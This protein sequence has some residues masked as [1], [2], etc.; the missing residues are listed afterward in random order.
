MQRKPLESTELRRYRHRRPTM[1]SLVR[2][3]QAGLGAAAARLCQP[4]AL[5]LPL[6][7]LAQFLA[8]LFGA[9][10]RCRTN[11]RRAGAI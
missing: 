9:V 10:A 11:A 2:L 1:R 3:A 7:T 5:L 4:V 6:L 8:R